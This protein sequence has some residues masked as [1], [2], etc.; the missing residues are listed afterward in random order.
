MGISYQGAKVL[1]AFLRAF[2]AD[3]R[4]EL[5]GADVMRLARVTSGTMYPLLLRFE[6]EGLLASRWEEQDPQD[7]GRPR[8]RL[9]SL[10]PE[11][12]KV[13]RESRDDL[14]S[15]FILPAQGEI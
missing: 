1:G 8:R 9:Y 14:L 2:E 6:N 10:T 3:V 5:A 12:C 7:L 4:S 15:V 13:A 11:G